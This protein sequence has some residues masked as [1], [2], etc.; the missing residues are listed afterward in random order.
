[1]RSG[2]AQPSR[3]VWV[4][5]TG[6]HAWLHIWPV[7]TSRRE[8]S[9]HLATR[10]SSTRPLIHR[11]D[12]LHAIS[13]EGGWEKPTWHTLPDNMG[14]LSLHTRAHVYDLQ[15][16]IIV[17]EKE[18]SGHIRIYELRICTHMKKN[19]ESKR[20][21]ERERVQREIKKEKEWNREGDNERKAVR[22]NKTWNKTVNWQVKRMK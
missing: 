2:L 13:Q 5:E 17:E 7:K 14:C 8:I 6:P 9:L 19:A 10:R 4:D 12:W 21:R 18:S 15:S 11:M 16:E 3:A 20:K 22:E 1:M